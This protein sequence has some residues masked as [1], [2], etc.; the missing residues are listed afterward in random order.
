[1]KDPRR[2]YK[3][4]AATG[5]YYCRVCSKRIMKS[6]L[7]VYDGLYY[8]TRCHGQIEAAEKTEKNRQMK[9]NNSVYYEML[10]KHKGITR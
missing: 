2:R 6:E 7:V 9:Y 3:A 5:Y 10:R 4:N 8:H 1:M